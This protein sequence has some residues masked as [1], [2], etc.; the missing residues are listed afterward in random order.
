MPGAFRRISSNGN[1]TAHL[2]R[3]I[4]CYVVSHIVVNCRGGRNIERV[5]KVGVSVPQWFF[6]LVWPR[7]VR[8]A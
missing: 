7:V 3:S 6:G 2:F 8:L 5:A 4:L 1:W